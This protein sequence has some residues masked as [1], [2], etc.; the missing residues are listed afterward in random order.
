M[1]ILSNNDHLLLRGIW[2]IS[3]KVK[4]CRFIK[5][6]RRPISTQY[7]SPE[8]FDVEVENCLGA[9]ENLDVNDL[10]KKV[11]Y[12]VRAIGYIETHCIKIK[13]ISDESQDTPIY[14]TKTQ[15]DV[16]L[17]SASC[18]RRLN[19]Q[20]SKSLKCD[21]RLFNSGRIKEAIMRK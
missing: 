4:I 20:I 19:K 5:S 2:N 1:R 15:D 17:E 21:F 8:R 10:S 9:L 13:K 18:C 14:G 6:K 12:T 11:V 16:Y 7:E 3:F